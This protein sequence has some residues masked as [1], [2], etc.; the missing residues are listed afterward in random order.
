MLDFF[1][2]ASSDTSKWNISEE[3]KLNAKYIGVTI[4]ENELYNARAID[5]INQ[6]GGLHKVDANTMLGLAILSGD[7]EA[8]K[9]YRV[10]HDM[11]TTSSLALEQP[12]LTP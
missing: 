10:I 9:L 11:Q 2:N 4:P 1:K 5:T 3:T 12:E 7:N 8:E 6:A